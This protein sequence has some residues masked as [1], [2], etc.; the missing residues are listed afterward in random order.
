MR[1]LGACL[2]TVLLAGQA[3]T[4]SAAVDYAADVQPILRQHCY[5]CHGSLRQK[6]GLRLDHA[7]FIRQG[8]D[9]GPVIGP[10]GD[11]SRLIVAVRGTGDIERMPLD[12][13]PLT[14]EQ[15]TTLEA[16]IN[17]GASAP[18]E[19]LPR[20]PRQHW[21]FQPPARPV[22]PGVQALALERIPSISRSG[23]T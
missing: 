3:S 12:A 14:D 9:G 11:A 13:K 10:R 1:R 19:P 23:G 16:W 2:M 15:I 18:E 6:S 5:S 21:A 4:G 7:T 17:Q 20:D 22:L 8:S